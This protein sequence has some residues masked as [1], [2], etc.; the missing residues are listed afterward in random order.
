MGSALFLMKKGTTLH[1][2]MGKVYLVLMVLTGITTLFMQAQVGP[3][4]FDHFGWIH[5]FS[6]LTL[7]SAP[8]AYFAIRKGQVKA[9]Q[10]SMIGLYV[11][12]I[13]IA[14]TLTF[15]PGRFLHEVF[16]K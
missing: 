14:G 6:V 5:S 1:K 9:H 10:Y 8:R 2:A 11:G 16:F 4:L 12:G 13:V 15:L 3:R 7:Y